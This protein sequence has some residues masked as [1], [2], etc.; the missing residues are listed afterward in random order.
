M[1][2]DEYNEFFGTLPHKH[3]EYYNMVFI[4][5]SLHTN[6]F[7]I[8]HREGDGG[9]QSETFKLCTAVLDLFCQTLSAADEIAVEATDNT[10]NRGCI[11]KRGSKFA[12]TTLVQCWLGVIRYF[13]EEIGAI[14]LKQ[15]M[16]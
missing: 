15:E 11:V 4:G 1:T 6:S 2:Q 7:T 8:G 13:E 5:A 12:R 3:R 10:D 14:K 9:E 16:A